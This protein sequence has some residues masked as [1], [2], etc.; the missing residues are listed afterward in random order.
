MAHITTHKRVRTSSGTGPVIGINRMMKVSDIVQPLRTL[1]ETGRTY[2]LVRAF[3]K[4]ATRVAWLVVLAVL[5]ACSAPQG[6]ENNGAVEIFRDCLWCPR[7]VVVPPG[8]Y[9]MGGEEANN[10]PVHRVSLDYS[11]AVGRTEVTQAQWHSVMDYL[12]SHFYGPDYPVE[13]VSWR[14]AQAFVRRLSELT[15]KRYRLLSEAEW[16]FLAR[17]H[18]RPIDCGT[19]RQYW[20]NHLCIRDLAWY[21]TTRPHDVATKEPNAL[22]IHDLFGNVYEWTADCWNDNYQGAPRDGRAWTEGDCSRRV[23]RGGAWDS[24]TGSRFLR[25]QVR[26]VA[27]IDGRDYAIGFR[28]ARDLDDTRARTR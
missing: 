22:G 14:D 10:T 21:E 28:V 25:P 18:D 23:V 26:H 15:G 11:F 2:T 27:G 17:A 19:L 12:P 16:E 24:G 20:E 8:R 3:G 1:L 7:M 9:E 5:V 4:R 6:S 13:H